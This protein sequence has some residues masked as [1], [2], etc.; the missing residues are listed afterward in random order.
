[1]ANGAGCDVSHQPFRS[2]RIAPAGGK[3]R[4]T[5]YILIAIQLEERD[6]VRARTEYADYRRRVPMILPIG[7]HLPRESAEVSGRPAP[8]MEV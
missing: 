5:V 8:S 6:L 7:S 3:Q 2:V 1:M 4:T